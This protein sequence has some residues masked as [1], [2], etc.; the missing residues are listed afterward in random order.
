MAQFLSVL[1]VVYL[2]YSVILFVEFVFCFE[3]V[4][5]LT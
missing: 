2:S 3:F 5:F 1:V 4:A